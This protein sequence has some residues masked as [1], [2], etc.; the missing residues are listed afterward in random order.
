MRQKPEFRITVADG[1]A[2][3]IWSF[4]LG[5]QGIVKIHRS[6]TRTARIFVGMGWRQDVLGQQ[7]R[8]PYRDNHVDVGQPY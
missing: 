4:V 1:P 2:K 5:Q 7:P 8:I 3:G 6:Q